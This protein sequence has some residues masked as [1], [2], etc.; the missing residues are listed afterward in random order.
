MNVMSQDNPYASPA[1]AEPAVLVPYGGVPTMPVGIWQ[2]RG[3]LVMHKNA[4][5]PNICV[6]SNVPCDGPRLKRKMYWHSPALYLLIL[7]HVLIYAVVA[8]IVRKQATIWIPL[9]EEWWRRR[10]QA[11]LI[12]WGLFAAGLAMVILGPILAAR[13]RS[14][15]FYFG[16]LLGLLTIIVGALYGAYRARMVAPKEIDDHYV[17]I[18]GVHPDYVATLQRFPLR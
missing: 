8:L 13:T 11:M 4:M 5:L 10:R 12:G 16:I 6:K 18:K 15:V 7:L 17:W 3:L 9:S 2:D 1:Y 14:D